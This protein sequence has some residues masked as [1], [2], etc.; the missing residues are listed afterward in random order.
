MKISENPG[1]MYRQNSPNMLGSQQA[2]TEKFKI[3]SDGPSGRQKFQICS[4]QP[5]RPPKT[6]ILFG[7][8]SKNCYFAPRRCK[9]YIK[10]LCV[11]LCI[12]CPASTLFSSSLL[13][14]PAANCV[15]NADD[16]AGNLAFK[17]SVIDIFW[18]GIY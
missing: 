18:S 4:D 9:C 5:I 6:A 1:V 7:L 14:A 16:C 3:C 2:C 13:N 17:R 10:S 15:I 12:T 8:A 11:H